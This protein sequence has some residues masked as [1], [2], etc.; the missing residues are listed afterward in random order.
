MKNFTFRQYRRSPKSTEDSQKAGSDDNAQNPKENNAYL[1]R[2][3]QVRKAQRTH[4]ERKEAYIKSLEYEVLQLRANEA[5]I[6]NETK[7][8]YT[9]I[10]KLK[11]ILTA[12]GIEL[13]S[14]QINISD[15]YNTPFGDALPAT[16]ASVGIRQ[17]ARK[18]QQIHMLNAAGNA[19]QPGDDFFLSLS[20]SFT[21]GSASSPPS[22]WNMFSRKKDNRT[23]ESS[24]GNGFS[25]FPASSPHNGNSG[26]TSAASPSSLRELDLTSVGTEFVLTLESPCLHH[27]QGDPR[28]LENPSGHALSLSSTLLFQSPAAPVPTNTEGATWEVPS[29][30]LERLLELS[31]KIDLDGEVTPIQ[32]WNL[33][34]QHPMFEDM[35]VDVLRKL[36]ERLRKEVRCFG[37]GA[38]IEQFAFENIMSETFGP[39]QYS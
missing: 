31:S 17:N 7:S 6:M 8:L 24:T 28:D 11:G 36:T 15:A 23:T 22:R 20:D 13:P 38:V 19:F 10:G 18:E 12:H 3:E 21:D 9:E 34:R 26:S 35:G 4:R 32:A 29:L 16:N 1:K 2:R 33:I 5:K 27:S 14:N 30:G 25:S 37:F 39:I